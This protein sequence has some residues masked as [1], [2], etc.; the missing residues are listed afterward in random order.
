V[1]IESKKDIRM[2]GRAIRE[3]WDYDRAEVA[4]ALMECVL[5][6][7]PELM[8]EAIDR[9]QKGD[10]VQIK[11]ELLELKKAGD[12]NAIRLRLLELARHI[13]PTELARLASK[14]GITTGTVVGG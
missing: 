11:R 3:G 2:I 4:K 14:N 8:F 5:N 1:R 7:D 6:R 12:D 9:L 10:E 13:E